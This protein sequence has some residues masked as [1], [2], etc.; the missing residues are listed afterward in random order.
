MLLDDKKDQELDFF[1]A[2]LKADKELE[3]G[4]KE[5]ERFE[6]KIKSPT[7]YREIL[8]EEVSILEV[9]I[10]DEIGV[11]SS[12]EA[13][14]IAGA[15]CIEMVEGKE[16]FKLPRNHFGVKAQMDM[17]VAMWQL[18]LSQTLKKIVSESRVDNSGIVY[19]AR[20]GGITQWQKAVYLTNGVSLPTSLVCIHHIKAK[21]KFS[22]V[23]EVVNG[24]NLEGFPLDNLENLYLC[25]PVASGMQQVAMIEKLLSMK[26][27]PKRVIVI[28]PM[29]TKFGLKT[30]ELFCKS[31]GIDFKAGVCASLLDNNLPL[32]YYSPYAKDDESTA[33]LEIK[34]TVLEVMGKMV[35]SFCIR[36][37][38][39]GSFWASEELAL[40]DSEKELATYGLSNR[41]LRIK[42]KEYLKYLEANK[43]IFEKL[44]PYSTKAERGLR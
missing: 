31:R 32:R 5:I 8:G 41:K 22:R 1:K 43:G 6:Y 18:T 16:V 12:P 29:G 39:T 15:G 26:V 44:V 3:I 33:D 20:E 35:N 40:N 13:E 28:A 10:R 36:C 11:I 19:F 24:V 21:N 4:E 7:I 9:K 30:V 42:E 38:W 37:N 34:K 23:A 27:K 2:A 14:S 17:E 25:D